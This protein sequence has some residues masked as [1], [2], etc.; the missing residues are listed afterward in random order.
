MESLFQIPISAPLLYYKCG[1]FVSSDGW[2]HKPMYLNGDYEIILG[3]QET[4]YLEVGKVRFELNP[5]DVLIIPPAIPY[6]GFAPSKENASFFWMHFFP[7]EDVSKINKTQLSQYLFT[8][9]IDSAKEAL[10]NSVFLPSYFHLDQ[11]AK[12]IILM[13]QILDISNSN[14][15][16]T[17]SVDYS[18][19]SL[20]LELS[21]QYTKQLIQS[22]QKENENS[23]KFTQILE[24]VRV[25]IYK[26]LTVKEIADTFSFN[27]DHL[28]RMFKKNLGMST[29]KYVNT[30]K[31]NKA[32][33]MLCITN[34]TIKEISYEL[35]FMDEKYFMKLFKSY[36]GMTPTQY[37][38]AYTH[39]YLNN[40][41]IDP[42]IPLPQHLKHLQ[43]E[44]LR[45]KN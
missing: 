37:R 32:K 44:S 8:Q 29:I 4:I 34:K 11:S 22:H 30:L 40:K 19:T 13:K 31:I 5:G 14:Y 39:I 20:L 41:Y 12:T 42:D 17:Y 43:I 45:R 18:V 21:N 35:H 15:H 25:N 38:D 28:T 36:E 6:Q 2:V 10:N 26:D 1:Q 33:E 3:L 9:D 7:R 16:S 24:W 27:P 23:Q